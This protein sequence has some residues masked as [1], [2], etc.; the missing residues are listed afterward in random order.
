MNQGLLYWYSHDSQSE[1]AKLVVPSHEWKRVQE[2]HDS[3]TAGHYG[4]NGIY[5]RISQRYYFTGVRKYIQD[6][7]KNCNECKRFKPSNQK[8]SGLLQTPVYGQRFETLAVDLFGP[9][10]ETSNDSDYRGSNSLRY[11][12]QQ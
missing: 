8:P 11:P 7:I 1:E 4:V 5:H 12:M 10:P 2:Y 9:L 6:Y 3:P